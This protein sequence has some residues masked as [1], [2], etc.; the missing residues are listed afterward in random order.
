MRTM[1]AEIDYYLIESTADVVSA[2]ARALGLMF[3][4]PITPR[5]IASHAGPAFAPHLDDIVP[6][7][8]SLADPARAVS[9][10]STA[11]ATVAC[12][13]EGL[14]RQITLLCNPNIRQSNIQY[15]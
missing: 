5:H 9:E 3:K 7:V 10:R 11:M 13:V 15:V 4:S 1:Q 8:L 2:M 14:V 12:I 6:R